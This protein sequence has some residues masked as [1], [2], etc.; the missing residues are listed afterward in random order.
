MCKRWAIRM[1]LPLG[2][3]ASLPQRRL[4]LLV[5][6]VVLEDIL[7]LVSPCRSRTKAGPRG[8]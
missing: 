6:F 8:S 7:A 3:A 2:F 4:E 5:V 1:H